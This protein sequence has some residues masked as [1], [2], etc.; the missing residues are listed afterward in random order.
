MPL[1]RLFCGSENIFAHN[2][3]PALSVFKIKP[4]VRFIP[5][6]IVESQDE[7]II[8]TPSSIVCM[9]L[10]IYNTLLVRPINFRN[11]LSLQ[12]GLFNIVEPGDLEGLDIVYV[13]GGTDC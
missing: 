10:F 12:G 13:L 1:L 4:L 5:L 2:T 8:S 3:F 9:R 6:T 7:P 11:E